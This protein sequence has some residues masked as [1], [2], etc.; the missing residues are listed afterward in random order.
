MV[1]FINGSFGV[2]K[3]TV[4]RLLRGALAGS[5]VYDPELFGFVLMRLAKWTTFKRP[6]ADDF[7]NFRLWRRSAVCGVRLFRL[8]FRGPV[9]VPMTFS[10]REYFDEVV[11]G[12]RRFDPEVRVFCLR[13]G[14]PTV[15]KRLAGRETES[16][17][18]GADWLARRIVECAE[19]H[20]DPHFGEPVETD[21][22]PAREVCEDIFRRVVSRQ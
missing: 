2:G 1:V 21:G 7:Q 12:V 18:P 10:R 5:A 13:A 15:E 22:R 4:A 11:A 19:A 8:L 9:I 3:T 20:R 6:A 14:L 16:E 17:G